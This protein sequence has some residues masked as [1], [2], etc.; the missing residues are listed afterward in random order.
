MCFM[1]IFT[2]VL[3]MM[4]TLSMQMSVYSADDYSKSPS[5]NCPGHAKDAKVEKAT[6]YCLYLYAPLTGGTDGMYCK[7]ARDTLKAESCENQGKFDAY[8]KQNS[9]YIYESLNDSWINDKVTCKKHCGQVVQLLV[10]DSANG[11]V[12]QGIVSMYISKIYKWLLALGSLFAV[13]WIIVGGIRTIVESGSQNAIDSAKKHIM[14]GVI[15]LT[16]IILS[17]VILHFINPLF[18][19]L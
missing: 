13:L 18:F 5:K 7:I 11:G 2:G 17:A 14:Q 4:F 8:N 12:F 19:K 6:D 16:L 10:V 9:T 1:R 3:I 15:G